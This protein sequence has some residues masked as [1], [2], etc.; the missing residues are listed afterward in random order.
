[1]QKRITE[2]K[3][4]LTESDTEISEE[5]YNYYIASDDK[6][7][8]LRNWLI[9][10]HQNYKFFSIKHLNIYYNELE[11]LDEEN[12][13]IDELFPIILSEFTATS[14]ERARVIFILF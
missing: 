9:D 4:N 5:S 11:T 3:Y 7:N 8:I 10:D 13:L 1:M 6:L 12:L 2:K 14:N